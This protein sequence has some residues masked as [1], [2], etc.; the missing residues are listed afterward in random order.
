MLD[1]SCV[2]IEIIFYK[3]LSVVVVYKRLFK[4]VDSCLVV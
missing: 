3:W 4:R 1:F 2:E